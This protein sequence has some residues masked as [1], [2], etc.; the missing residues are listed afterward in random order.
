LICVAAIGVFTNPLKIAVACTQQI[1]VLHDGIDTEYFKPNPTRLTPSVFVIIKG[2]AQ[3]LGRRAERGVDRQ[4][5][6][7]NCTY[8]N[9]KNAGSM[10]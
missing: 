4:A 1:S 9:T 8:R 6:D 2:I 7:R 10:G 3:L 5:G